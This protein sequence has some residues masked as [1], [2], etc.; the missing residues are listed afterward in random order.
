[1]LVHYLD[2][3]DRRY[4]PDLGQLPDQAMDSDVV[5][6]SVDM[7]NSSAASESL[8]G[9]DFGSTAAS[10]DVFL[11]LQDSDFLESSALCIEG[12]DVKDGGSSCATDNSV[13]MGSYGVSASDVASPSTAPEDADLLAIVDFS[14]TWAYCEGGDK[15]LLFLKGWAG[16]HDRLSFDLATRTKA[17][18]DAL[19]WQYTCFFDEVPVAAELI[20]TGALRTHC[21]CE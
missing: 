11:N 3:K 21:P 2:E 12:L 18:V 5:S 9:V 4:N 7:A 1:V 16:V 15:I 8:A 17:S 6:F 10:M 13:S 20:Q 14:P 19:E